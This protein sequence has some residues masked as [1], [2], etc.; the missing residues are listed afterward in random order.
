MNN[1]VL[2]KIMEN[3]HNQVDVRLL[4]GGNGK[5]GAKTMTAKSN[6]HSSSSS[7]QKI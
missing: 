6:F 3:T 1:A 4:T 7:F 5:Y 2:G